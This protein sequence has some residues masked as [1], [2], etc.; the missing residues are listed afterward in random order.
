MTNLMA[1]NLF[2]ILDAQ[3][4]FSTTTYICIVFYFLIVCLN[5]MSETGL[6]E[7]LLE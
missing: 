7:F 3:I 5:N 2:H 4:I 6:K 1:Q